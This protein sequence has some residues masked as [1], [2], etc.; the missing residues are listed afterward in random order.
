LFRRKQHSQSSR[1]RHHP[2][3]PYAGVS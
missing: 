3:I 1:S 2:G